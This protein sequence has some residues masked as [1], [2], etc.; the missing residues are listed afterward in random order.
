MTDTTGK[1]P[2]TLKRDQL[3]MTEF[4]MRKFKE[5][6]AIEMRKKANTIF[7][8]EVEISNLKFKLFKSKPRLSI[9]KV[10]NYDIPAEKKCLKPRK[11]LQQLSISWT[12]L[13]IRHPASQE[14]DQ[15]MTLLLSAN[16]TMTS[17]E[18]NLVSTSFILKGV[19]LPTILYVYMLYT[20]Y[21]ANVHKCII[22]WTLNKMKMKK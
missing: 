16:S 11:P 2:S 20:V 18:D 19:F 7:K 14:V 22:D 9:K 3:R 5:S 12:I 6:Y 17:F 15:A 8:L 13:V 10:V 4:N 1:S 21:S